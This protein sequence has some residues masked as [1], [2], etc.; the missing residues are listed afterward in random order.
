[1]AADMVL[2][3]KDMEFHKEQ[4]HMDRVIDE[5]RQDHQKAFCQNFHAAQ[6]IQSLGQLHYVV[7]HGR[8]LWQGLELG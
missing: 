2:G 6:H 1:M 7:D 8:R 3:H 5:N 4:D